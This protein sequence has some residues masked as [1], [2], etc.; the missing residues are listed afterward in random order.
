VAYNR[1]RSS[2]KPSLKLQTLV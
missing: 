2:Q 1:Y